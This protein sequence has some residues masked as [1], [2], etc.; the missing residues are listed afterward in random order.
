MATAN[1]LL[2]GSSAVMGE[3][4]E[5]LRVLARYDVP[6]FL[7]GETG[8][9]KGAAA[10]FLHRASARAG[11]PFVVQSMTMLTPGL[12]ADRFSGHVAGSFTDAK[13]D[14]PGAVESANG[15]SLFLDEIADASPATQGVL[16]HVL[17]DTSVQRSGE[18]RR[19]LVDVRLILATNEN[20]TQAVLA[21]AFRKDLYHRLP[22]VGVTMPPLRQH[23][24]DLPE[25]AEALLARTVTR[26]RCPDRSLGPLELGWLAEYSWPGNVRELDRALQQ[27]LIQGSF[28]PEI[29][30]GAPSGAPLGRRARA[31]A[32]VERHRGN[33]SAAAREL[34]VTRMTLYRWL[35][36]DRDPR[37]A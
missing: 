20:L 14:L 23:L 9:G 4:R 34:G 35:A 33:K 27:W 15:G 36:D 10:L 31:R 18:Y 13:G 22:P 32:T 11:G 5:E 21:R 16:L 24:D 17:E 37:E 7:S 1:G 6:V 25:L 12:E 30:S 29:L 19:R 28:P 26:Y 2:V 3:V 8:T